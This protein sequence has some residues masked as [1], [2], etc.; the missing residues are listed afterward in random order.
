[1]SLTVLGSNGGGGYNLESSLRFRRSA[2]P[3]LERTP[4]SSAGLTKFTNSF[5]IKRGKIV[6]GESMVIFS[7]GVDNNNRTFCFFNATTHVL[8]FYSTDGGVHR[9]DISWDLA[10]RDPSAWYHIVLIYDESNAT[11]ADKLILYV[12]GVRRT[13][14]FTTTPTG[15]HG[16]WWGN[17]TYANYIGRRHDLYPTTNQ[18]LD[19]YLTEFHYVPNQVLTADDFGEYDT[20]TGV[21]KPKK[22]TGTY[23]NNGFY[24]P[25]KETQQATG[26]NTVLW[27]GV[28]GTNK[29]DNV[30]FQP[31]LVWL[32]SRDNT[33]SHYLYDSVRG[34]EQRLRLPNTDAEITASGVTSF[35][36]NGFSLG[37]AAGEDGTGLNYVAWCWDAGS[38]TVS[39]TDGTITANVRANPATGFSIITYTGNTT[40]GATVGHG[41]G[42][43]PDMIII[44]DRDTVDNWPVYHSSLGG[45]N[46]S[47]FL[48]AN[49]AVNTSLNMW[50][51]TAPSS[52]VI[53]LGDRDEVNRATAHVAYCFSEV[54]GFSK[55]GS[56]T[57]NGSSSGP[58]VT[59]GFRPAFVMVKRTDT[60]QNWGMYDNTRNP[61]NPV[62]LAVFANAATAED[63]TTNDD[64]DFLDTG[65]QMKNTGGSLNASGGTYIYMAFADTRDAQFNFDA[66]GNKNNWTANNINSNASSEITYDI[67][68]DV[69]TLTDEDTA[70]FATLNPVSPLA[71]S[72]LQD[73]N[74]QMNST[75]ASWKHAYSTIALPNTG[76]WYFE[77]SQSSDNNNCHMGIAPVES[78]ANGSNGYVT[79]AILTN[80]PNADGVAAGGLAGSTVTW[81]GT[82]NI[83]AGDALACAVDMDNNK[84]W[85]RIGANWVDAGS[86]AGNPS[87]G[88]NPAVSGGI[89]TSKTYHF[90]ASAYAE[91][92]YA[93][94]G[95]RP[96]QYTVPTG[97]KKLNTY[98][99]PDSTIKDGS[100]Y[101]NTVLYTG[102]GDLTSH[103]ITGVG[104]SPDWI[105]IKR[106]DSANAHQTYDSVRTLGY[107]LSTDKTDAEADET[108]KFVSID[109]DGF[110]IKSNAGSHNL[111]NATYVAWN[112]R[113]S[114]SSPVSNTDGTITSTVS[115][116]TTSGFS[117][118]TW[119]GSGNISDTVGTGLSSSIPLSMAIVKRR[120]STSEWQ[121][122]HIGN[123]GSNFAYHLELNS[124]AASSGSSPYFM[125]TQPSNGD[126]INLSSGSLT[127][128]ATYV[129]YCFQEIE[130]FSKFGSYT[131]NGSTDGPFVYTGFRPAF[132]LFKNA[133]DSRQW[134]IVDTS[135]STYNQTNATLEPS[136][137]N[138]ENPYDDF[139][140][141]S[142]GFKPRTT[143]P[144]SNRSGYTI[145]YMA[146]AETPFKNSLAR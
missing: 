24:L 34:A 9:T 135:R 23:G 17:S 106:R 139:D 84:V 104:F 7:A 11:T 143:D 97:F 15:G 57:G 76:K 2:L 89:N 46:A 112:W 105:W 140:I 126:K 75:S 110:T 129:A 60:T 22:Y 68:N 115:A 56:Y 146:F 41:L 66:S 19:A 42:S 20:I 31:D 33:Y 87:A 131:G 96:F 122:G 52:S 58:T 127:S 95:Q 132:I 35:D 92:V 29:I 93:N 8:R 18:C 28:N 48:E 21:W 124:T 1:M 119:T 61:S 120:D 53:T 113:G 40:A 136:T 65:F 117:I 121:V 30:G 62:N 45:G 83:N 99:L 81:T 27:T 137:S 16:Q 123:V 111:L 5:W 101:M 80:T 130:G 26:F 118:V 10:F 86:G 82:Y 59:T 3:Y 74:L 69:P 64:I 109:S 98:N 49:T 73:A 4:S 145:I 36:S 142:N 128:G 100:Q 54:A 37:T 51:S 88:T 114:D 133:D 13:G 77:M 103:P 78:L 38:S 134:G 44:K 50:N 67:M 144:G 107:V 94:F 6:D 25:M 91:S 32:K 70:N 14:T 43:A 63:A 79:D 71:T 85:F 116:N 138:A 72:T 55:F 108:S 125:G 141:L 47:L 12:N 39:N 90:I 102:D